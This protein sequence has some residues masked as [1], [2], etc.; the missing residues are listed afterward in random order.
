M[1]SPTYSPAQ[2]YQQYLQQ[3]QIQL[4]EAAQARLTAMLQET[5]WD[6]PLSP[7]DCNNLA[8]AALVEADRCEDPSLR[9]LYLE[10]AFETLDQAGNVHPLCL[11]HLALLYA[12]TGRMADGMQLAFS[13]FVDQLQPGDS[14][15]KPLPTGLV[16]LPPTAGDRLATMLEATDGYHQ[17][18]LVLGEVLLHSQ[19]IFYNPTGLRLLQLLG[20]LFPQSAQI[21]LK[22]GISNLVNN[23]W[24][25]LFHLHRARQLAPNGPLNLQ[26]L[27]L[28][29]R[30]LGQ[31]ATADT[32]LAQAKGGGQEQPDRQGWRWTEL[33]ADSPFT[34]VPFEANL[35]V[36]VEASF[37]SIVTSVLIAEGD[38]FEREMEFWRSSIEP[39]MTVIDVGANVGVYSFSAA[40]R[41]GA[42]GR[43]LAI[44]PFSGC[45]RCLE[46]TCRVNQLDQVKVFA[47]AASDRPGTAYLSLRSA[48][49]LNQVMQEAD[50]NHPD[51]SLEP[52]SCLTLDSLIE[53]EQLQ[54]VDLLK[55][56]AEGHEM[57]VLAG[58]ERL[59]QEFRP[60]IL[61]ENIVGSEGNNLP[62]ATLLQEKN[63]RLYAYQ[64]C[65][66]QLIPIDS[67]EEA[68][69]NL[70][71]IAIP[72]E[73]V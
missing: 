18:L 5:Q 67:G 37:R 22:L 19:L 46:E 60:T 36:A 65:V 23:Q 49:E 45:V 38:W 4:S 66:Q 17:G 53:S 9:S 27:Y 8:A 25:G 57:K 69:P 30:D 26:A 62:V 71:I 33:P 35:V 29:Y 72:A 7:L 14:Q 55:I 52:I 56:D 3:R 39:G 47:G 21:A 1:N 15:A 16:Y 40:A 13:A 10:T 68:Q 28:A 43:V 32:W 2:S 58:S 50:P 48:S 24:E 64:P 61:Y 54:R 12:M 44:E 42:T 63:Y 11:A 51:D 59:L 31:F 73:R 70:N 20:Y 6:A 41:V 34:Y